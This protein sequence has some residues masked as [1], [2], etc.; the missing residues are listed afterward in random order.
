MR[1]PHETRRVLLAVSNFPTPLSK[2]SP[3]SSDLETSP[4]D[5]KL[6]QNSLLTTSKPSPNYYSKLSPNYLK[7]VSN[8]NYE[9]ATQNISEQP[10]NYPKLL[11]SPN[12]P[13]ATTPAV[14]VDQPPSRH[15][16]VQNSLDHVF[17]FLLTTTH[18]PPHSKKLQSPN[19]LDVDSLE[20]V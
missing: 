19:Y 3:I 13:I 9:K 4:T 14:K 7:A 2:L 17:C 5:S 10:Q 8:S 16:I 18:T 15:K 11:K 12:C 6:S 1:T 20:T